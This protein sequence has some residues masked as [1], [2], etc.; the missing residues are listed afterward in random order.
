MEE[1][2]KKNLYLNDI[3]LKELIFLFWKKKFFITIN[4]LIF[5]LL[6]A[7]FSLSLTNIYKSEAIL[8]PTLP[9]DSLSSKI[10]GLSSIASISGIGIPSKSLSKSEEGIERIKSFQFFSNKFLP[11]INLEDL[12]AVEDW[13][14]TTNKIIYDSN[15]F[16]E[17]DKSWD[18]DKKPTEQE[19]YTFYKRML[20]IREN[21][22]TQFVTISVKHP[23]PYKAKEWI[24]IIIFNIN[25]KM[26]EEDRMKAEKSIDFLSNILP[27]TNLQPIKESI[28][29]LL[30]EQLQIS[31]LASSSE[32]YVFNVLDAPI[33]PERK[34]EPKIMVIVFFGSIIGFMLATIFVFIRNFNFTK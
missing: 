11:S 8:I 28:S 10:S 7:L 30:E 13:Q 6:S 26:R 5:S 22:D 33:V 24:D 14:K 16:I 21:K 2:N 9:N 1:A 17:K 27:L 23:S 18:L 15:I 25:E 29:S 32:Y 3:D 31:M 34:S 20:N 19:A 12:V 4:T